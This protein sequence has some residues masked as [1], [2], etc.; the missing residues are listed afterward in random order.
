MRSVAAV[1][2]LTLL[3]AGKP[4]S[5]GQDAERKPP[6]VYAGTNFSMA[7]GSITQNEWVVRCEGGRDMEFRMWDVKNPVRV[8]LI[9]ART[10]DYNLSTGEVRAEGNV[11]ITIENTP[12][13]RTV[14]N[15]TLTLPVPAK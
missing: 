1:L 6:A 11:S 15:R 3:S 2:A 9:K 5:I 4:P 13:K 10:I 7:C 8:T 12:N 14:S